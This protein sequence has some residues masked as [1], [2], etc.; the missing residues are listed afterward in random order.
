MPAGHKQCD[1][2]DIVF[3]CEFCVLNFEIC[4]KGGKRKLRGC[5][6]AKQNGDDM[7][8]HMIHRHHRLIPNRTTLWQ[9]LFPPKAPVP[10]RPYRNGDSVNFRR[11]YRRY[12]FQKLFQKF[13]FPVF[14]IAETD[15]RCRFPKTDIVSR[16]WKFGFDQC[17]LRRGIKFAWC[18]L[19][20][21]L[22]TTPPQ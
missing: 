20:A 8:L 4:G 15:L 16:F 7:S 19:F 13:G 3:G 11:F 9:N 10:T 6:P 18:S 21:K 12:K 17:F 22:G 5:C 2:R 1:G 14:S